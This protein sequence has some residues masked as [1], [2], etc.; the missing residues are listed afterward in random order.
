MKLERNTERKQSVRETSTTTK[1][2]TAKWK[3]RFTRGFMLI[4]ELKGFYSG[5]SNILDIFKYP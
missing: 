1:T 4:L 5:G 2:S 3:F